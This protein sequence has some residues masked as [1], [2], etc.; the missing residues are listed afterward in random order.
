MPDNSMIVQATQSA[1]KSG[2][3]AVFAAMIILLLVKHERRKEERIKQDIAI[4]LLR[5]LSVAKLRKLL[6]D[7]SHLCTC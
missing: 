1:L 3:L 7:A 5:N 2:L 6:G 4:D